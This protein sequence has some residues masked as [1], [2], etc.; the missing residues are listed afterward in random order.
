MAQ[1][2]EEGDVLH[3]TCH[4]CEISLTVDFPLGGVTG[5]CPSCGESVTAPLPSVPRPIACVPRLQFIKEK[6]R[7]GSPDES[8]DLGGVKEYRKIPPFNGVSESSR[9]R[10]E[11]TTVAKMFVIGLGVLIIVLGATYLLKQRF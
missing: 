9:E 5:P 10:P 8:R 3:F 7:T 11:V 1:Q 2:P 4:H 6:V